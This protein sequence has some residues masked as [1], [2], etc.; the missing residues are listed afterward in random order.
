MWCLTCNSVFGGLMNLRDLKYVVALAEHRNFTRAA[1]AVA[2]SQPALSNQIRKLEEKLGVPIF[3]RDRAGVQITPFGQEVLGTAKQVIALVDSMTDLARRHQAP[4]N[5][6]I[7][8]GM[9]PTLAAY[10]SKYFRELFNKIAEDSNVMIFEEYPTA[11]AQMV[12]DRTLD[13]AFI[14]RNTFNQVNKGSDGPFAF[15]SLWFEEVYLAVC[16][17]NPLAGCNG[18]WAH[19]VPADKLIRFSISFGFPLEQDLPKPDENMS[20]YVG[21]DVTSA[22]FETVCRYVAQSECCTIV[23]AIA[24]KQFSQDGFGLAFVPFHD[25]GRL[26]ELGVISRTQYH[27]PDLIAHLHQ[28]VCEDAPQGTTASH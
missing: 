13:M 16:E 25:E 22:R 6:P 15:K 23:N 26:R 4:R 18:I 8:L 5:S 19:E 1:E 3:N 7:R 21:I 10:L 17:S 2:V 28:G 24:A 27:K 14:A 20:D 11:L 9:T 12:E